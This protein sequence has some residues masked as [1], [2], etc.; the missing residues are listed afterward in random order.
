MADLMADESGNHGAE[1]RG[2]L[3]AHE[4]GGIII[5]TYREIAEHFRLGGP[6]A[7]RTKAKRA[8]WVAEPSNHPADPL[9]VRVPRDAWSH[10][11]E[12]R[13]PKRPEPPHLEVRRDVPS[14]RY[15]TP[16][17]KALEGHITT[18]QDEL[19]AER[20][21]RLAAEKQRDQAQIEVRTEHNRAAEERARERAD[22]DRVQAALDAA[23]ADIRTE[24][25]RADRAEQGRDGERA[26]ADALR[27]QLDA[28][29]AEL[30]TL[31][32]QHTATVEALKTAEAQQAARRASGVL[33][34]LKR[35]WRRE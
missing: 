23:V 27:D 11:A 19:A 13:H 16:H 17:I 31:R 2:N 22:R 7:A 30:G 10:Q 24:R 4:S 18:L 3:L 35:A 20:A 32:T 21:A 25:S 8:G 6:N 5:A 26:R 29:Q 14:P 1:E 12:T 33:A 15:Q 28:L 9:R 34:R